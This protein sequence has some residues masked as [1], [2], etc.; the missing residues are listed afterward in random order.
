MENKTYSE[1]ERALLLKLREAVNSQ[2]EFEYV[3]AELAH[4][5]RHQ[6]VKLRA[7][8]GLGRLEQ[9]VILN[10]HSSAAKQQPT[11]Q[12]SRAPTLALMEE[13]RKEV[14]S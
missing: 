10:S 13:T 5:K 12:S 4:N 1:T 3:N 11:D 9:L 14:T 2:E 8:R 6:R 7:G